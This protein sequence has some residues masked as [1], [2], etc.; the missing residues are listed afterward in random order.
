MVSERSGKAEKGP[1]SRKNDAE[2]LQQSWSEFMM[3]AARIIHQATDADKKSP[4][5][6]GTKLAAVSEFDPLFQRL[7][8]EQQHIREYVEKIKIGT[9]GQRRKAISDDRECPDDTKK[10]EIDA[11]VE[12]D[13]RREL[14]S[15][16]VAT[17][18]R[19]KKY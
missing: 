11:E 4:G 19:R 15:V 10:D 16:P 8:L 13:M 2:N 17:V 9:N 6:D 14:L 3:S 1:P 12:A 18:K 5:N 7:L